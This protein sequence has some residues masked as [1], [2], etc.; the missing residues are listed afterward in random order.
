MTTHTPGP[1]RLER[2]PASHHCRIQPVNGE[3]PGG[4]LADVYGSEANARLMAAAPEL[5]EALRGTITTIRAWHD[6][7][8]NLTD[9]DKETAWRI[10]SQ[11]APE[12]RRINAAIAKAERP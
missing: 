10:Y 6:M 12:M 7:T 11:N 8:V 3:A 9:A 4:S 2:F 5:L 1:W